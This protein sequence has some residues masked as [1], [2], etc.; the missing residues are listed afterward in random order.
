MLFAFGAV[1]GSRAGLGN[2]RYTVELCA[3]PP[4][5]Y[6]GD[7]DRPAVV[8]LGLQLLRNNGNC[9]SDAGKAGGF[10]EAAKLDGCFFCTINFIY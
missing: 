4:F 5:P 1:N 10:G 3:V 2:I 8:S 9:A 7:L 6:R